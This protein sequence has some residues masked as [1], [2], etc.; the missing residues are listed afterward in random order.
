MTTSVFPY[1]HDTSLRQ[2]FSSALDSAL[3]EH[4]L[5]AE[6]HG[7]LSSVVTRSTDDG[8][9]PVRVD[10]LMLDANRATPF[11]LAPALLLSHA[12]GS[13]PVI[14]L[15]TLAQGVQRFD[16]RQ[17]VLDALRD[18]FSEADPTANFEYEKIDADPFR[19]QM[20]NVL[21]YQA[22]RIGRLTDMLA[23]A[24]SLTA[25][26]TDS[27]K[28]QLAE[29]LP[30]IKFDPETQLLQVVERES[31][32]TEEI[33]LITQTLAQ[34]AFEDC[35]GMILLPGVER[36]FLAPDG[37]PLH[38]VDAQAVGQALNEAVKRVASSH[39]AL[40]ET[41]WREKPMHQR[42]RRD[43]A[44]ESYGTSVRHTAYG[45]LHQ[46]GLS[47]AE[48]QAL[49]S[50]LG[51][52]DGVL[53]LQGPERL[54]RLLLV[55]DDGRRLALAGTFV[56]TLNH[57]A[58]TSLLWFSPQHTWQSFK[59]L[60]A[61]QTFAATPQGC[62][63]LRPTLELPHRALL[64]DPSGWHLE[65]EAVSAAPFADQIDAI[66]SMQ[67]R[68]L[69][70]GYD[71][72]VP[73]QG[74]SAMIDDA[75]DIRGLIDPRQW[76]FS[77]RRWRMDAPFDFAAV[78]ESSTD[79][80]LIQV[81]LRASRTEP[82]PSWV[83]RTQVFEYRA[84]QLRRLEDGLRGYAAEVLQPYFCVLSATPVEPGRIRVHEPHAR[85]AALP[86]RAPATDSASTRDES[87]DLVSLLLERV[88]GH[89]SDG[90]AT[91]A[92]IYQR[93][94]FS[95][96]DAP[97]EMLDSVL[98]NH[99]LDCTAGDFVEL[100]QHHVKEAWGSLRR[101]EDE[102]WRPETAALFLR[103]DILRMDLA[104]KRRT[105]E[106]AVDALD[107]AQQ[108]MDRSVR[109]LRVGLPG[110]VTDT[111]LVSVQYD[112]HRTAALSDLLV[113][114]QP[115]R[116][117]GPVMLWSGA[118]GWC[119]FRSVQQMQAFLQRQFRGTTRELMLALAGDY[120]QAL[121]RAH[122][123]KTT[124]HALNIR[125]DRVDGHAL[126]ALQ[127]RASERQQQSVRQGLAKAS[128]YELGAES[129]ALMVDGALRDLSLENALDALSLRIDSA[130]MMAMLPSWL[131]S[132]SPANL[133]LYAQKLHQLN[134]LNV[135]QPDF[136]FDIPSLQQYSRER[137]VDQLNKDFPTQSLDPDHIQVTLRRYVSGL[138]PVGQLP[139]A[140]PAATVVNSES[141]TEYALNRFA[142]IQDAA[143]SVSSTDQP[144]VR[145]WLTPDYLRNLIGTLDV[146]GGY[147]TLL[148]N[149][150]SPKSPDYA[151]RH[152]YFFDQIPAL[153]QV[154][155]LE[156]KLQGHLSELGMAY[157]NAVVTMPDG[158]ARQPV[159]GKAVI[160]SPLQLVAD[161]GM[162]PDGVPGV[163]LICAREPESGP[164]VLQTLYSSDFNI[165]EYATLEALTEDIRTNEALQKL[166]LARLD[167]ITRRRYD[168]GG[169]IEPHLPFNVVGMAEVPF[170][171]PGPVTVAL[172]EEK[173]NAL[174]FIFGNALRVLLDIGRE[175]TVTNA[176][177]SD[178]ATRFLL[179]LGLEQT[180]SLLPG[181][182]GALVSLW[183]SET[184]LRASASAATGKRWGEALSEFSAALGVLATARDQVDD[185]V[186]VEEE[187][188][189][190]EAIEPHTGVSAFSWGDPQLTPEQWQ[191]IRALEVNDVALNDLQH[192]ELLSL[193]T[194]PG[195]AHFYASVDGRVYRIARMP[196][197]VQWTIVGPNGERGP[198]IQLDANQRWRMDLKLSLKGGGGLLTRMRS[199]MI[200]VDVEELMVVQAS[201][202]PEIRALYRDKA[203][204]IGEAQLL[205][206][207]YLEN[208]LD[209]LHIHRRDQPLLP[210]VKRILGE[211]FGV[212]EP[213]QLLVERVEVIVKKLYDGIMDASLSS[214]SSPRYVVGLSRSPDEGTTGFVF[215]RDPKQRV[216]LTEGFFNVVH[217]PLNNQAR[218]EGF[219]PAPH[220]RAAILI[221]E[222]SHLIADTHDIT[223]L[224]TSA[225]YP[226]LLSE[227]L[228]L[229]A[230]LK[231]DLT[232]VH[233]RGMS[234]LSDKQFLFLSFK[235]GQWR[236]LS[237]EDGKGYATIL[238]ITGARDLDAA[239]DVFLADPVKRS[240]LLLSNADSVTLLM[241]LLGRKS[242]VA[243]TP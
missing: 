174:E 150:L 67:S 149:A 170:D 138:T 211:F 23:Q 76:Q 158:I 83:E 180:M 139:S 222:L 78:W 220:F 183:Q 97:L 24:P 208:C 136:L 240:Q 169:F 242:Y 20:L 111:F 123:Q 19:A 120:D 5:T 141:L 59:G 215:K 60:A 55:A 103:E 107:M 230:E 10:S 75:L 85:T 189:P 87:V 112:G 14:Y 102:Q 177:A 12:D 216:F 39:A 225:P 104:I 209:N 159:G 239:R 147:M 140:V 88:S 144:A 235:D 196:D 191:R 1:F 153:V 51:A 163:Y 61:L 37:R 143:L 119:S 126:H 142:T 116:E 100:Y 125:L 69:S 207:R 40:L 29:L 166:V 223:Y 71:L 86:D 101:I 122:L 28:R 237:R 94:A 26:L 13:K 99:V 89:R 38:G 105:K 79:D 200:D 151:L 9:H 7:W 3:S 212:P 124:G 17:S 58:P 56:I 121:L 201:G 6:E 84:D 135:S 21:D 110:P 41:F 228:P 8:V 52:Q 109:S 243:P 221:H 15:Y 231:K 137:L 64:L 178:A 148:E 31:P 117:N 210:E 182:L 134:H 63:W 42:S 171:T 194:R 34:A 62:D 108:V 115:Q 72:P 127:A 118:E 48:Q 90:I 128:R 164:V 132:A 33:V 162:T 57:S 227:E 50:L 233:T 4:A 197:E 95:S 133:A 168:A 96:V 82:T 175:N 199:D 156:E 129:F 53:P 213:D 184:L 157:M 181:K 176:E 214:H 179:T 22:E 106:L 30:H 193:Y 81:Q 192:D 188:Q 219:E 160:I 44:I 70:Y 46:P 152:Q 47:D 66:I 224:E 172:S 206:K 74:L 32:E 167:P 11:E 226:D 161:E 195:D 190:E 35:C 205:G 217:Y 185:D 92:R 130:L 77:A 98:L 202:M 27:L 146:G 203:R 36:R 73:S 165:K 155:A 80:D 113:V 218:L 2:R 16:H 236:D 91:D 49:R 154:R 68:N 43:E 198:L 93:S 54:C 232:Y 18:R 187:R 234:H 25:A 186:L 241:L 45:R 238:R 229:D 173:G 65:L 131:L 204:R 114:W 145:E